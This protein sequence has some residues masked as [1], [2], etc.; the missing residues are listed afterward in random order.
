MTAV[1]WRHIR[2][3]FTQDPLATGALV[4]LLVLYLSVGLAGFL[5]PYSQHWSNRYLASAPPTPI[6]TLDAESG[7]S[8]LPYT[9]AMK[10]IIDR[11]TYSFYFQE[12][13][14]NPSPVQLFV[15]GE[16]YKLFGVI[17]STIHLFGSE[18][19]IHLL[20]TDE[21]GRDIFSRML[22]G[23]QISLTVG[24]LALLV[25]FPIGLIYGG[26][27]GYIGGWM[28]GLMMRGAEVIMSIPGL[29]L[30]VSLA[31]LIPATLS[32]S[33]R[34]AMVTVILALIG[35]AG[36][37]RVIRGMVLSIKEQE[38][39]EAA[40][41]L[42]LNQWRIITKHLLPQTASYV[43]VAVT[44][45]V[46]GYLLAESGLSFLGLGIQQPDASWGNMLKEAQDISNLVDR[47]WMLA[48]GFLIFLT[49]LAFNILGDA[50]RDQFDPKSR[51]QKS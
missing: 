11:S 39:V 19:G 15:E 14:D 47:P 22:Y 37:A 31:A 17:P 50:L 29:F 8:R 3:R 23:G 21:N 41:A 33:A 45:G 30:L 24:F 44:V 25:A 10:R 6:Y 35:W 48:P 9:L 7:T 40:R 16:P 27:S 34:F 32:S 13:L 2:Q 5:A 49:V 46:P 18:A 42:G 51:Q 20:G 1:S 36:L 28:D 26:L 4:T 38:Y 43:I 12:E